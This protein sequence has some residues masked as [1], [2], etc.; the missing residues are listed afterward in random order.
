[1]DPS[2]VGSPGSQEVGSDQALAGLKQGECRCSRPESPGA[3]GCKQK[4][5]AG[6]DTSLCASVNRLII[7]DSWARSQKNSTEMLLLPAK[8]HIILNACLAE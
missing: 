6:E 3:S 5:R 8:C 2:I 7:I 1:M 4:V